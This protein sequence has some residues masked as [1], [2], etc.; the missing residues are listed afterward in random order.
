MTLDANWDGTSASDDLPFIVE[1]REPNGPRVLA[2]ASSLLLARAIYDAAC[3][4][5]PGQ[6][7][8]MWRGQAIVFERSKDQSLQ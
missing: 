7:I 4:E 1:M 2:K 3:R 6:E 8:V 5:H